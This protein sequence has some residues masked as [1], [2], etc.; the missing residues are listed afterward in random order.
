[1]LPGKYLIKYQF[2]QSDLQNSFNF[3]QFP[4]NVILYICS[5]TINKTGKPI[6]KVLGHLALTVQGAGEQMQY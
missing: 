2:L 6:P 3:R 5:M 1:V 4:L